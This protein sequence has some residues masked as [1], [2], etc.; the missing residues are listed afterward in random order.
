MFCLSEKR[1]KLDLFKMAVS[2]ITC[3]YISI[4]FCF[5]ISVS[6]LK[7]TR[8]FIDWYVAF[9]KICALLHE[10]KLDLSRDSF[11]LDKFVSQCYGST[12]IDKN[13]NFAMFLAAKQAKISQN[14]SFS[15]IFDL[16]IDFAMSISWILQHF[17]LKIAF[18][19]LRLRNLRIP[20]FKSVI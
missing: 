10:H 20:G 16:K 12:L 13:Q 8:L 14:S 2:C 18:A 3:L 9:R 11:Y 7:R 17:G 19:M 1:V 15:M 5:M 4:Y 6:T